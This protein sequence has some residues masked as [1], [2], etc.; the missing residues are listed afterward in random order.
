M[1]VLGRLLPLC[2]FVVVALLALPGAASA[3]SILEEG[4]ANELAQSLA[5]A[6]EEQGVCYGWAISVQDDDT[7]LETG[8]DIGSSQGPDQEL[9]AG[10]TGCEKY[11]LLQGSVTYT[12][13]SSES[14]DFA[15]IQILSNLGNP[16]TTDELSD[17]GYDADKLMAD[18][19]DVQLAN[20]VGALPQLVADHGEA[21][22]VPFETE[23]RAEGVSGSPTNSPG[24]DFLRENAATLGLCILLILGGLAWLLFAIFSGRNEQRRR[25]RFDASGGATT[26]PGGS[27]RKISP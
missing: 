25:S 2:L 15:S 20:M 13:S 17:L 14:E 9:S 18:D 19:N 16:P 23:K 5:E 6:T 4:D 26:S 1:S 11:V 27:A 10:T 24:S 22:P 12:S 7:G 21:P 3:G 8:D